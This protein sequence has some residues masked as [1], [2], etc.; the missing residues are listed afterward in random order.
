MKETALITGASRG[1]GAELARCHAEQGGDLV[2]VARG[3]QELNTIKDELES[4]YGIKAKVIV[5]DLSLCDS[6][7][8]LFEIT[9][10]EG[11]QVDIL[12]NNAGVGAYGRF[13][14]TALARHQEVMQLNMMALVNLTHYYLQGMVARNRGKVMH[15]ASIAGFVP[16]P[17]HAVYHASKAFVLS[18]SQAVAQELAGTNV[19]STVL[20]PG[21]VKTEFITSSNLEGLSIFSNAAT[22]AAV[23]RKGYEAM[24]KKKL[25]TFNDPVMN[26]LLNW[27]VPLVPKKTLL[28]NAQIT[29]EKKS[30]PLEEQLEG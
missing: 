5:V 2:L 18:F 16:G 26:F 14:E 13:N 25:V 23:A 17:L 28:K 11:I 27:V 10:A 20:C 4:A 22:P 3:E 30:V 29:M 9:E 15:V 8:T 24:M 7:R 21:P 6:A 1:I 12:I 19:S